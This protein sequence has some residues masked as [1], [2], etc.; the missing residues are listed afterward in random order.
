LAPKEIKVYKKD[1]PSS[2]HIDKFR[3][4]NKVIDKLE[5]V[6]P[7][8]AYTKNRVC[9]ISNDD[10]QILGNVVEYDEYRFKVIIEENKELN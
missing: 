4:E 9:L 1:T 3:E 2:D 6:F 5:S 10:T 7:H 8:P